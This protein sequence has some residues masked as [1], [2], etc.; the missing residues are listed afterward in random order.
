M[1]ILITTIFCLCFSAASLAQDAKTVEQL[2]F[3]E[4]DDKVEAIAALVASGSEKSAQILQALADGELY[5]SG[6]RVL[7]VKGEGA[8]DAVTGEKLARVP[9]DKEDISVNNRLRRELNGAL[10]ALNLISPKVEVRFAAA[11]ELLG[12]AEPAMLALVKKALDK[13]S[14]ADIKAM[15]E[16]IAAALELKAEDRATR[17]S[18]V[19][20]LATSNKPSTKTLLLNFMEN[21]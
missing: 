16:Q 21:E 17:L 3:G 9:D 7:I 20:K 14:N 10:A 1:R 5:T 8:T 18:A 12:G 11:K 2:A 19:R 6:K 13:E 15:L 4:S